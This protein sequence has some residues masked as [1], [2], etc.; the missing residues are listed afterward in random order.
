MSPEVTEVLWLV[1]LR[2]PMQSSQ[3]SYMAILFLLGSMPH[4][5]SLQIWELGVI[6]LSHF[7]TRVGQP[8]V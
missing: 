6:F 2:V 4:Y 8:G 5:F 7:P 1:R 3:L